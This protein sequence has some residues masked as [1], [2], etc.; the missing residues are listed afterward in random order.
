MAITVTK[1]ASA[2]Y[3]TVSAVKTVVYNNDADTGSALIVLLNADKRLISQAL[4][5]VLKNSLEAMDEGDITIEVNQH[6]KV[7]SII[8]KDTGKGISEDDQKHIF[9]PFF[10]KKEKGMGIGLYLTKKIIE[11]HRGKIGIQ[12]RPGYGTTFHIQIPGG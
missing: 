6:R 12:S 5:N 4:N 11:A 10:S 2:T 9:D 3:T 1:T 7:S 8:I